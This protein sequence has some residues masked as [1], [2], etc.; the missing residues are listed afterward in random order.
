M[1][2]AHPHRNPNGQRIRAGGMTLVHCKPDCESEFRS[3]SDK[4]VI[5]AQLEHAHWQV[6][7]RVTDGKKTYTYRC[8]A[9]PEVVYSRMSGDPLP[10]ERSD[11]TTKKHQTSGDVR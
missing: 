8:P 9:H 6:L 10:A 3:A 2:I 7:E 5:H 11:K 1:T 4:T